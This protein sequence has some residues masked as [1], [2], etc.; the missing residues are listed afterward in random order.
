MYSS[1]WQSLKNMLPT[2]TVN[3]ALVVY[4]AY[5][6]SILNYDITL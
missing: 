5:Y 6:K 2:E 1:Y 3:V 4:N